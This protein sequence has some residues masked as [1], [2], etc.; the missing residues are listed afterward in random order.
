MSA[1]DEGCG[2]LLCDPHALCMRA[3]CSADSPRCVCE[4]RYEG[5]GVTCEPQACP[6]NASGAPQCLCDEGYEGELM[7]DLATLSWVVRCLRA[8]RACDD[9]VSSSTSCGVGECRAE[10]RV[11]CVE[12]EVLDRCQARASSGDDSDCD[13]RDPL[14]ARQPRGASRRDHR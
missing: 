10:G 14:G 1:S 8:D 3:E 6:E 13:G 12:G 5:D 4:P 2:G 11:V 7:Y 9:G